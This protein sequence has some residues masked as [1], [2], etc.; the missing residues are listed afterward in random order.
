MPSMLYIGHNYRHG[1]PV[2]MVDPDMLLKGGRIS[3]F[4]YSFAAYVVEHSLCNVAIIKRD[5]DYSQGRRIW[6]GVSS[7]NLK[8][9]TMALR[10]AFTRARPG[11]TLIAWHFPRD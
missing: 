11:D 7:S 3:D 5:I 1:A 6:V 2:S 10:M 4:R 8:G 9:S